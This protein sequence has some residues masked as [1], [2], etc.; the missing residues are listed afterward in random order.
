MERAHHSN[1]LIKNEYEKEKR[2]NRLTEAE[3]NSYYFLFSWII[4]TESK[5]KKEIRMHSACS[6]KTKTNLVVKRCEIINVSS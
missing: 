6:A 1:V 5:R 2:E 3:L 4:I